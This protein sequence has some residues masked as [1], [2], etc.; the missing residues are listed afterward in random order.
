[1]RLLH[2]I[3]KIHLDK[4][5]LCEDKG[6]QLLRIFSNEWTEKRNIWKSVISNKIGFSEKIYA[7][8]C[9]IKEIS[10]NEEKTFLIENHLQG[11]VQSQIKIGLF[12]KGE[13]VSVMTFL[14]SRF[15]KKIDYELLRFSNKVFLTVVGGASKLL[16][17]FEKE[18]KPKSLISYANRRWSNGS[19]YGVLGFKF[20]HNTEPNYFY[21]KEKENILYS[22]IKFQ[23]H[24][25]KNILPIYDEKLTETE[26]MYDN[27]YRKIYDCGNKVY[28]KLY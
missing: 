2:N 9:E 15:N 14:K 18:Y 4:T 13:L 27:G 1:M 7:R 8:N 21:F 25:L 5:I 12:Y 3:G 11:Y 20:L 26:N 28:L 16:K 24:K 19:L 22:R 10:T 6:Y 17:Y 23:K